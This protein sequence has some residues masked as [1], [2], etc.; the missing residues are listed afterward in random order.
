M[1]GQV[2]THQIGSLLVADGLIDE[3]QL[4]Y[5]MRIRARLTP[6]R[7][8]LQ[9]LYELGSVEE[10]AVQRCLRSHRHELRLGE[11]L[12]ELGALTAEDLDQALEIQRQS[13]DEKSRIGDVLLEHHFIDERRLYEALSVQ[14][15]F[16]FVDLETTFVDADLLAEAP[17]KWCKQHAFLPFRRSED[18]V[19][20]VFGDPLDRDSVAAAAQVYGEDVVEPAV[21]A[22]TALKE[23]WE[24]L[25]RGSEAPS[26]EDPDAIVREVDQIIHD[27]IQQGAS[28]IHIEPGAE[29]LRVR[30][31]RDGVLLLYRD[32]PIKDAAPMASRVKVLCQ[33]NIA[34][35]R[36]HQGG[37]FTWASQG[38]ELDLRVSIYVT[39]HGEK[40]VMRLLNRSLPLL[41]IGD[42]GMPSRILERFREDVLDRP[43]GVILVTGP[44]GSGK[45]TT[46]YSAVNHIKNDETAIITAEDPV[47][48]VIDGISQCSLNPEI[49]LSYEETLRH[50][51]RQDPDV[52][53]IG[54][55]RDQWSA[56][57]AIQAAL[58]G[59]KVISTFHTEDSIGG[60]VRLLNMN[61]EAFLISSTVVSI[62]SQRLLRKTCLQCAVPYE[63]T[64]ADLR[65]LGYV[66][67]EFDGAEMRIGR[68]CKTCR[69]TGYDGRV[70][71]HELLVLEEPVRE[72]LLEH[73]T[74]HEIRR[75]SREASG[76]VSLFE[77][78]IVKAAEGQ[79]SVRELT[80]MLPRL[81][82]PRPLHELRRLVGS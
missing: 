66:G 45:T 58:T 80:R 36:R 65:R 42:L 78:G 11:L 1:S 74:S 19:V 4:R 55:I 8:L 33:A 26:D 68:G 14:L 35:R 53:V 34:E 29:N 39:V 32:Y 2:D 13:T 71:I 82:K 22:P 23:T 25:D 9:I 79:T 77:D 28:D 67:G 31:R 17:L 12:I 10:E 18:R 51:V 37:R 63:P 49:D 56:E 54:E 64:S 70:A 72:A 73:K 16:P 57:T 24:R 47:E 59:H 21:A 5:A 69:H 52:I 3:K 38:R 15:G 50:I 43:S 81:D 27:A 20:V 40:I 46:L 62:L 44:T 7:P 76:L 30:F 6:P 60:L 41:D 48:Y 61:I 75:I